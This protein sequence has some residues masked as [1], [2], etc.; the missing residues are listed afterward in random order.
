MRMPRSGLG[1]IAAALAAVTVFFGTAAVFRP[2]PVSDFL[3]Y[4]M[5]AETPS[6]YHKGGVVGWLF[7]PFKALGIAPYWAAAMLNGCFAVLAIFAVLPAVERERRIDAA[8]LSGAA[9]VLLAILAA[10]PASALVATDLMAFNT[11]AIGMSMLMRVGRRSSG[12]IAV[13]AVAALALSASLR[14]IYAPLM[15][16]SGVSLMLI[17]Y[18]IDLP[19]RGAAHWRGR[20]LSAGMG[21][22]IVVGGLLAANLIEKGLLSQSQTAQYAQGVVRA[23]VAIG[24][25]M[26]DGR[27]TCGAWSESRAR[28]GLEKRAEPLV[29]FILERQKEVGWRLLPALY[30]CKVS[31]ILG[32]RD[33]FGAWLQGSLRYSQDKI[34]ADSMGVDVAMIDEA[35]RQSHVNRSLAQMQAYEMRAA[36]YAK[37]SR[38]IGL[39]LQVVILLFL[40]LSTRALARDRSWV[41]GLCA[42]A[43]SLLPAGVLIGLHAIFFEVQARYAY[44]IWVLPAVFMML[45]LKAASGGRPIAR[46]GGAT[47]PDVV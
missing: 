15:V 22:L 4:W 3:Y 24:H 12:G 14:P 44:P 9:A 46:I 13:G 20:L 43:V 47:T 29:P 11:F 45:I 31:R 42:L 7:S 36:E 37:I 26:G 2:E 39:V 38:W 5:I 28:F 16:V 1:R 23:V 30:A 18:E 25:D 8:W 21:V 32:F 27:D 34:L 35:A 33:W 6:L 40:A 41:F 19:G 10:A 17:R